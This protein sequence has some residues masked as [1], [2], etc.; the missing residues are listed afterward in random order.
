MNNETLVNA[1]AKALQL[2]ETRRDM[3]LLR[4]RYEDDMLK[5]DSNDPFIREKMSLKMRYESE[6]LV[7]KMRCGILR[8]EIATSIASCDSLLRTQ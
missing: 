3:L 5:L 6:T 7:L 2:M 8:K 1:Q 4:Q